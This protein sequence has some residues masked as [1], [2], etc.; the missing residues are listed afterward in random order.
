MRMAYAQ[1]ADISN[2]GRLTIP[3]LFRKHLDIDAG[4]EVV[5]VGGGLWM[6]V[7]NHR[8]WLE[9]SGMIDRH[10]VAKGQAEMDA[11]LRDATQSQP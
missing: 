7:W 8:R 1:P 11:S 5:L 2:Q 6:E 9:E 4:T 3:P 10:A